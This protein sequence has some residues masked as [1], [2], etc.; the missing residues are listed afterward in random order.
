MSLAGKMLFQGLL[1]QAFDP[2]QL[3]KIVPDLGERIVKVFGEL[4]KESRHL[5]KQCPDMEEI[6]DEVTVIAKFLNSVNDSNKV[7]GSM[8]NEA[9]HQ[10]MLAARSKE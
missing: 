5:E 7:Y 6:W 8:W 9:T 1:D 10:K 2:E 4:H 3:K